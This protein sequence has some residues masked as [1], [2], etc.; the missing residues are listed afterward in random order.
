MTSTSDHQDT[1]RL[2]R[3]LA[4]TW[5]LEPDAGHLERLAALP[6]LARAA[7]ATTPEN[8]AVDY[9]RIMLRAVPPYASLFLSEDAMLNGPHA[10]N[11]QRLYRQMGFTIPAEWRAGPA[12][13]LGLELHFLAHL[14]ERDIPTW[15]GFLAEYLLPWAPV[16][17]LAVERV[18]D[19]TLYP[20]VARLTCETLLALEPAQP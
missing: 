14:L 13:H 2:L 7:T 16:C 18:E 3:L 4:T 17:C 8:A 15:P 1:A 12:D 9:T 6:P 19:S 20:P 5:L 10:E 11:A